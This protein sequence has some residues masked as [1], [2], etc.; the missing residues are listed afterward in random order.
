M[1]I[2]LGGISHETNTYAVA[3]TGTTGIDRFVIVE[4]DDLVARYAGTG[5]AAGG[6][7]SGSAAGVDVVPTLFALA[8]PSG[9]IEAGVYAELKERLLTGL[10]ARLPVDAVALDLH[11]AGVVEGVDD[12][13]ADLGLAIRDLV[14]PNVPVGAV[15]DLHGNATPA[16]ASVYDVLL[17]CHLY[18]HTDLGDRGEELVDLLR[19][20]VAG[21]IRP[22]VHVEQLPM[23]LPTSTTDGDSPAARTNA[24][25]AEIERRP[26]VL[27]CTLMHGFPFT[28]VPE[29]GTSVIV[30]ADASRETAAATGREAA[31]WVWDHRE[32]F[33]QEND[34]PESAVRRAATAGG[35]TGAAAA[36]RPVVINEC[37]DNPGGGTPGDGTH[38]LRAMVEA[39]LP[40]A[41]FAFIADPEVVA[42]AMAAG[43]GALIDVKLG[44][45]HDDL[46]GRPIALSACR[47]RCLTDGRLVLRAM[48]A[49]V[50]IDLGPTCRLT[51]GGIDI[52]VSS[53]PFQTIDA[54][55]FLM[56][57]IDVTRYRVVGLK[58]S[59]HFRAGFRDLASEIITADSPGLTTNRVEVFDH[60]RASRPLWPTD[61]AAAYPG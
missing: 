49:G 38:L 42:A 48:L 44:G 29:V 43:V 35:A 25:F 58:S 12:L 4:G 36:G 15:L 22:V 17:G 30:V 10:A 13:E 52:V 6:V 27:D 14:G 24:R 31:G 55:V 51:V 8:E 45:K 53:H 9:T 50:V 7:L 39:D 34:T 23:L 1:R 37:S 46:H 57:G 54:E 3:S 61:V 20:T 5:T 32:D 56:H 26:G 11:G 2:A 47:V 21:A 40:D 16:M 28:D 59:N 18:P 19:R 33:R 60:P 41:C